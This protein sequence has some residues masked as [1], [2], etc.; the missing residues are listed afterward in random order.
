M[1][2]CSKDEPCRPVS[3]E[4]WMYDVSLPV[5][6]NFRSGTVA[7]K[8]A[9]ESEE[10]LVDKLFGFF[11]VNKKAGDLTQKKDISFPDNVK[12]IYRDV[13]GQKYFDFVQNGNANKSVTYYYPSNTSDYYSFYAY[14]PGLS[15]AQT[16]PEY[17]IS[18]RSITVDVEVGRGNDILWGEAKAT[19]V[20][21]AGMRYEG[22]NAMYVRKTG[23]QPVVN[24]K[25]V[26][27]CLKLKMERFGDTADKV[28]LTEAV[29]NSIPTKVKL[30]V[31]DLADMSRTGKITS[32][33]ET[34]SRAFHTD[35]YTLTAGTPV[36]LS[37]VFIAPQS[38][39]VSV[40]FKFF[41]YPDDGE[42]M[43]QMNVTHELDPSVFN[44]ADGFEEG[45]WYGFNIKM[46]SPEKV[47]VEAEV[48]SYEDAFSGG[49]VTYDPDQE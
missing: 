10:D 41:V 9:I 15:A 48:E 2:G 30:C 14:H 46:Y 18:P 39:P 23:N 20:T 47:T 29:L 27:A 45:K 40:T 11:A 8:A 12:A 31:L 42:A 24:F 16:T 35:P 43:Y 38:G 44:G 5:P 26:T 22:F 7:S 17:E 25:H 33:L 1:V 28:V 19:P 34:G 6:I 36:D 32:V 4:A 49:Y 13:D 21:I 3:G 37:D